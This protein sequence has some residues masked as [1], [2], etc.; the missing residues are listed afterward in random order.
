MGQAGCDTVLDV[1]A[2]TGLLSLLAAQA[3]ASQV[4]ACEASGRRGPCLPI[5]NTKDCSKLFKQTWSWSKIYLNLLFKMTITSYLLAF[6]LVFS[7]TF[8]SW[9]RI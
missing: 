1:G 2:G 6:F 7:Q 8:P 3:G 4:Y 5:Q 9:I